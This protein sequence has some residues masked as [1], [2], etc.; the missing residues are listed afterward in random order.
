[1][2][3][4]MSGLGCSIIHYLSLSLSVSRPSGMLT[5]KSTEKTNIEQIK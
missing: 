2:I 3:Y 1:M 4:L 5:K